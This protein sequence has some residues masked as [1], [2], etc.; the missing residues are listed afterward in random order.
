M[1]IWL[2]NELLLLLIV[3]NGAP[4][5]IALLLG[6]RFNQSLDAG[7]LFFDQRPW[8]GASKTIRGVVAAIIAS[9]LCAPLAGFAYA[10]GALFGGL[11]MLGDL[12]SSF[13]KRRLGFPSSCSRPG[14]D[15][16]PETLL[17]LLALQPIHAATM[18][19]MAVVTT[20]FIVIDLLLSRILNASQAT[21]KR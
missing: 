21:C 14:L 9:T 11:A 3:A 4:V 18:P 8:L 20:V 10:Y 6:S 13:I 16:L 2:I 19:E 5:V 15:Q 17:P 1:R 12:L 7:R